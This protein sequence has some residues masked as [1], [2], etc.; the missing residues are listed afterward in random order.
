MSSV[1]T[2]QRM[3]LLP[4]YYNP[5]FHLW[6]IL[7]HA[8]RLALMWIGDE[9]QMPFW[10][11]GAPFK[12]ILN[13][14]LTSTK[15]FM[16]HG[17]IVGNGEQG[18]MLLGPGGSGKSTTVAFSFEHGLSVGGDDLV[19]VEDCGGSW[20]AWGLYNAL[21]LDAAGRMPIPRGWPRRHRRRAAAKG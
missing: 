19:I 14:F 15:M 11:E 13:W 7:D 18:C 4:L 1:F 9:A 17:G 20:R 5:D 8:R 12:V 6:M 16:V 2:S 21:K 3:A 10:E